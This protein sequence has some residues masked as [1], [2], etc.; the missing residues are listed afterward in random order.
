MAIHLGICFSLKIYTGCDESQP[1]VQ[2]ALNSFG[3]LVLRVLAYGFQPSI[4]IDTFFQ[5]YRNALNSFRETKALE[6]QSYATLHTMLEVI[7]AIAYSGL[8]FP[9][10]IQLDKMSLL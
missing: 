8:R 7:D 1:D 4:C 3:F 2:K 6:I 10:F 9:Y 5:P